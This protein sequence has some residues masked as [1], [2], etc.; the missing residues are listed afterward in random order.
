MSFFTMR[1]LS[2]SSLVAVVLA[3]GGVR[4]NHEVYA[5]TLPKTVL[6][7]EP[8]DTGDVRGSGVLVDAANRLVATAAHV[9]TDLDEAVVFFPLRDAEGDPV[10][11][12]A[13]YLG[14]RER[15]G[16]PARVVGRR[17][18]RDVAILQLERL[19]AGAEAVRLAARSAKHGEA[20]YA[21][22]N[23]GVDDGA[24]WRYSPGEV[25]NIYRARW[26]GRLRSYDA[27][28]LETTAP[29][30]PGDSGGPVVN[31]RGELVAI[32]HGFKPAQQSVMVGIDVREVAGLLG[33]VRTTLA[34]RVAARK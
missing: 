15:L 4:A 10:T 27:R 28:I 31:D 29:I 2:V 19:P 12:P 3:A 16:I 20:V 33:E 18:D 8:G 1:K 14:R 6:V 17:P 23:S 7:V 22:G 21:I 13:D 11:D 9:V 30:N 34:A 24:L 26:P 5:W 25:R 32:T